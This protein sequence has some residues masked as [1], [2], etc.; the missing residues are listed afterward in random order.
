MAIG[1][2]SSSCPP[3]TP[4]TAAACLFSRSL[5][6]L[7][8]MRQDIGRSSWIPDLVKHHP[9]RVLRCQ[10]TAISAH[11]MLALHA[12][13]LVPTW[14]MLVANSTD[15]ANAASCSTWTD[16]LPTHQLHQMPAVLPKRM[17]CTMS[18]QP[19]LD[20]DWQ[21]SRYQV[22]QHAKPSSSCGP[23]QQHH[24]PCHV[25]RPCTCTCPMRS[26]TPT[27]TQW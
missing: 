27:C 7:R 1:T 15:T 2:V 13:G 17:V 21:C 14:R 4:S 12:Q 5:Q 24:M 9:R 6:P 16:G 18:L 22:M 25:M 8:G 26:S 3:T 11:C 23:R 20:R 19:Q 10:G